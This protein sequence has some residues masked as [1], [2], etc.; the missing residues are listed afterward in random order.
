MVKKQKIKWT[1][2]NIPDLKEKTIIVT[3]ANSGLGFEIT[4][5]ISGKNANVIMACRNIEKAE[6][7]RKIILK[8]NSNASLEIMQIDLSKLSTVK[9][10]VKK[11]KEKYDKLD[12]LFNN[13]GVMFV[14]KIITED[15]FELHMA[16]NHFGHFALTGLLL[17]C[18]EKAK[19]SR[20]ISVSS[21]GHRFGRI[22]FKKLNYEKGIYN[23]IMAYSNCKIAVLYFA[24]ELD[25][26]LK[27]SEKSILSIAAH[28]GWTRT[29]LQTAGGELDNSRGQIWF[30]NYLN[31]FFSQEVEMGVLPQLRAAFDPNARGGEYFSPE[32]FIHWKGYPIMKLSNKRSRNRKIAR[33][34]WE[35]SEELTGIK[36]NL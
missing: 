19:N 22:N 26:R 9:D 13:A 34:F 2:G 27:M 23:R 21:M 14:P 29:N 1:K 31:N 6:Q 15:G 16:A 18:L 10:F 24:Y 4:R 20:V 7:A 17:D 30:W 3:G 35:V 8:E 5:V 36:Y 28:P 33:K 32:D 11:F 12:I 25:H